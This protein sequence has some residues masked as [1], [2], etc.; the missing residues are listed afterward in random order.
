M[1]ALR[2][3]L[4]LTLLATG[5]TGAGA[6][7]APPNL[8]RPTSTVELGLLDVSRRS[9]KAG[10]YSGLQEQGG[11]GI[12][13]LDL[14][15]GAAYTSDSALR[16]RVTG[17]DLGV[18]GRRV[19]AD[20]G[21]Q[22]KA[23][24]TFVYDELLRNRSD[25]YQ[26]IFTGVGSTV[27]AL[28]S[29]WL[30]PTIAG[31]TAANSAVNTT[32]AR[33]LIPGIG[34]APYIDLRTGSATQGGVIAPSAAQTAL[35]TAAGTTD[36]GLF[37]DAALSTTRTRFDV[38]AA[39]QFTPQWG[40]E[41]AY[42]P[43]HKDG[44]KP[45]GAISRATG[46]DIAVI[47]PD[48][49]DS[50]D[51]QVDAAVH[52]AGAKSFLQAGYTGSFFTNHI[53]SMTFQNWALGP[54]DALTTTTMSSA[55][56]NTFGQ[57]TVTAGYHPSAATHLTAHAAYARTTQNDAFL[58][59]TST[60][61]VP[62]NSLEGLV[63]RTA[64]DAK[65]TTRLSKA[66]QLTA[67]YKFDDRANQT[68]VHTY[69][70]MDVNQPLAANPAF[71]AGTVLA[72]NVGA[73]RAYSQQQHRVTG[74]LDLRVRAGQTLRAGYA[75]EQLGRACPGSWIDCANVATTRDHAGHADWRLTLGQAF[76]LRAGAAYAARRGDY[77]ENAFLALVPMANVS[78]LAATGGMT[79]Y[80]YLVANNLNGWGP[81]LGFTVT[82]GNANVFFPANSEAH[83]ATYAWENRIAELPGMRRY[84]VANRDYAKFR[85]SLD[86]QA[87]DALALQVGVT[88]D[89]TDYP[90]SRY[91]MT[92]AR[93]HSVSLDGTYA[94]ET[95]TATLSYTFE[96]RQST[97][98]GNTITNSTNATNVL[99]LIGLSNPTGCGGYTTLQQ[100]NNNNK[101]DP[102]LDW[103]SARTDR[104]HTVA[105]G[106]T[107]KAGGV[108]LTGSVL[109]SRARAD[110]GFTGGT[111]ANNIL[112][113][114]GAAPTTIAATYIPVQAL[115]TVTT[116]A[117]ELR[118][119]GTY[120]LTAR[121]AVRLGY[122]YLWMQSD[123]YAYEG[124][125]TGA[126]TIINVLPT[127]ETAFNHG[128]HI[129]GASYIF[130]F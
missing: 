6:Q 51:H 115:P 14:R 95:R 27:L 48:V 70:F 9:F 43:E 108:D 75:F 45:L 1:I 88:T 84:D 83:L 73:N 10:E 130:R 86:W 113:G 11:V 62:V 49:V 67:A 125:Q 100:R 34:T 18:A 19:A 22:G 42:R 40:V 120:A 93:N 80:Q 82:T 41:A 129:F 55:P 63:V 15:G 46:G 64:V 72:T 97:A 118:L 96:D 44:L 12:G 59:D 50:D 8:T 5:A 31:A 47:I 107:Q 91:G 78:P 104:V 58:T 81:A 53:G 98:A 74:D 127:N 32:S 77:N 60:P 106:L 117:A 89:T 110:H 4:L 90:D 20:V 128:V 24:L 119:N 39:Y 54:T 124:L 36:R 17:V 76:T 101:L 87:T 52:F 102:C 35:V 7:D 123:D 38:A 114:P 57:L 105:A 25:S 65:A 121:M 71:T 66:L 85:S 21:V 112:I 103:T 109:L 116:D 99:G 16:W 94:G 122:A 13:H 28:P 69:Q 26:S 56:S 92:D 23:R 111:W 79:Y 33:G 30:V 3:T 29:T 2:S 37:R 61:V 68:A 126:T